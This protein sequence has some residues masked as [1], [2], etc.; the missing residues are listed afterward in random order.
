LATPC[1]ATYI[2]YFI[3]FPFHCPQQKTLA[4]NFFRFVSRPL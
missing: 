3:R 1:L 2:G 4:Y